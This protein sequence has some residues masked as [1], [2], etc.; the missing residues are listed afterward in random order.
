MTDPQAG[1]PTALSG[2]RVIDFSRFLPASYVGWLMADMGADVIRIEHPRELAKQT[3]VAGAAGES[4]AAFHRRRALQTQARNKRSV[5]LNPG[6]EKAREAIHRLIETADV[7]V[8]DYRPGTLARMGYG[9][10][11]MQALNP[12]LVYTSV[13]FTG[14][15]GPYAGRAG[16]DPA[17]LSLAGALSRLNGLP[18]P[19]MPGL[20]VADVLS[21]SHAT[22]ATL[23]ALMARDRTGRG[24]RVDVAMSDASAPLMMVTMARNP[25]ASKLGPPD[26]R[27]QPKGGVWE[28]ADG[29]YICT[30]D[31]ETAY[32]RRFCDLVDRPHYADLQHATDQHPAMQ[33]DLKAIFRTRPRDEWAA[34]FAEA[35]TQA[36][37]VLSLAEAIANEHNRARG[38]YVDVAH[39]DETLIHVGTPF[40]LSDTPGRVRHAATLP[41]AHTEEILDSLGLSAADIDAIRAEGGFDG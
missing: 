13:S 15:T 10:P 28:C 5:L 36:M 21:G 17:A 33:Q 30:T 24:Q 41:G 9:W 3:F 32:W 6:N 14:Q 8:E 27:W 4:E 16:H 34:I 1:T 2:I 18:T 39:G 38:V 19:T 23:M 20:Q 7:L 22:I 11:E 29:G 25:D 12:R 37:P 40:H 35:D 31:M 26:A